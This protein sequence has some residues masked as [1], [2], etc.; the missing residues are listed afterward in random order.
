MKRVA[1]TFQW[2]GHFCRWL[3]FP[4]DQNVSISRKNFSHDCIKCTSGGL[5]SASC[6]ILVCIDHLEIL[7]MKSEIKRDDSLRHRRTKSFAC[8]F[9]SLCLDSIELFQGQQSDGKY[10]S[11][12][13]MISCIYWK[14][15]SLRHCWLFFRQIWT[16]T[17]QI[18]C[19]KLDAM[20]CKL[21]EV[22]FFLCVSRIDEN[23]F[24]CIWRV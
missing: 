20:H 9:Q 7:F 21:C 17:Q 1:M 5:S 16:Q 15:S 10:Q 8:T 6:S 4:L 11:T 2:V 24:L 3:T 22:S 18:G 23:L 14:R 13:R 12:L 19:N